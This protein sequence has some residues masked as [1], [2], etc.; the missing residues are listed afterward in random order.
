MTNNKELFDD[1]VKLGQHPKEMSDTV[2]VMERIGHFLDD[3]VYKKYKK[4]KKDGISKIEASTIIG[5][6]LNLIRNIKKS[7]KG[8]GW[9][10]CNWRFSWTWRRFYPS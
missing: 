9:W 1:L 4:L 5:D 3:A 6:Q 2:T 10:F 7:I 8:L